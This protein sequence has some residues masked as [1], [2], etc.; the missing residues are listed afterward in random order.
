M[1]LKINEKAPDFTLPSTTGTSFSLYEITKGKPLIL[2]FYPKDFTGGCTTEACEFRDHFALFR[3][4]QIDII[5]ISKDDIETH[6]K[7]KQS[8]NLPFELLSDENGLVAE[9]YKAII[10]VIKV[11][12]RITY[13]LDKEHKIAAVFESMF[14]AAR[15]I[16]YMINKVK[17]T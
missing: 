8:Y 15:H 10:P 13:L 11:I 3:N 7:F 9:R 16:E 2:Y 4:L 1:P 17:T 14:G 12:R 6:L 5:G